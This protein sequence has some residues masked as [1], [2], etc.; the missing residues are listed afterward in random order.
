MLHGRESWWKPTKM[1]MGDNEKKKIEK[2]SPPI[3]RSDSFKANYFL[4]GF[5]I[6]KE[7]KG[8]IQ[9]LQ[10]NDEKVAK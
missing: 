6:P 10:F 1:R 5:G 9:S 8:S 2:T 4:Q 3:K 7:S